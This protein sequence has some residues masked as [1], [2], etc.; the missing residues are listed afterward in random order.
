MKK[1]NMCINVEFLAGTSIEDALHEAKDMAIFLKVAY[2][3]FNFNGVSVSCAGDIYP[4]YW[5]KEYLKLTSEKY[6]ICTRSR[7][8]DEYL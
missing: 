2:L 8:M 6:M 7:Q 3:K 1:S 4:P 5:A